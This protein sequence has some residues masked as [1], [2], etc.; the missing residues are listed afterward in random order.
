MYAVLLAAGFQGMTARLP[1]IVSAL[2]YLHITEAFVYQRECRTG[3]RLL[4]RSAA[5][6]NKL[7]IERWRP[8]PCNYRIQRNRDGAF[9]MVHFI[10]VGVAGVNDKYI[11]IVRHL[12]QQFVYR[13]SWY[14]L[15]EAGR[16]SG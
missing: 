14:S 5:I 8:V 10:L 9:D 1:G 13:N 3:T 6:K 16:W 2:Q 15:Q 11:A 4:V 7:L 12:L